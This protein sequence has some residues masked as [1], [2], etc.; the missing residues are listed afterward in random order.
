MTASPPPSPRFTPPSCAGR[1]RVSGA[2]P[3]RTPLIL[4]VDE[5]T[6][7]LGR[8]AVA[9]ELGE[10]LERVAQEYRKRSVFVCASGQI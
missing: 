5:L 3:D 8:S 6:H 4:W 1:R 9:D 7:L 2:D 10:L